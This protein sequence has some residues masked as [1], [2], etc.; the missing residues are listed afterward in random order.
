LTMR[1]HYYNIRTNTSW[2]SPQDKPK[3][4]QI[5]FSEHERDLLIRACE[6]MNE[7]LMQEIRN[8]GTDPAAPE[9]LTDRYNKYQKLLSKL[10]VMR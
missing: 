3:T 4:Q 6:F 1:H 7:N 2:Q 9:V 5:K 8:F 10:K